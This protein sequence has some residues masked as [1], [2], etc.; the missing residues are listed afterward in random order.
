MPKR[1]ELVFDVRIISEH[2]SFVFDQ[3]LDPLTDRA[4]SLEV[5]VS[6][7]QFSALATPRLAIPAVAELLLIGLTPFFS[8]PSQFY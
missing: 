7:R 6:F 1:I 5:S 8:K 4:T 2:S 3:V